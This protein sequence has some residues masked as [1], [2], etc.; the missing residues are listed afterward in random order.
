[1]EQILSDEVQIIQVS[2]TEER[3]VEMYNKEEFIDKL[4][5]PIGSLKNIEIL[6]T[7]HH[8]NKIIWIRFKQVE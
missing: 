6:E 3:G 4:T 1:M 5:T 7:Q 2:G 8:N